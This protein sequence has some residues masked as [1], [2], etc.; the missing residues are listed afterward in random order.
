MMKASMQKGVSD[1]LENVT[2]ETFSGGKR[3][4]KRVPDSCFECI[5]MSVSNILNIVKN[6]LKHMLA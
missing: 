4:S 5:F 3:F 1:V 6:A 2:S